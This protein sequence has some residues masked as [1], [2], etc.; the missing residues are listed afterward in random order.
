MI[1]SIKGKPNNNKTGRTAGLS[2]LELKNP[3]KKDLANTNKSD[4]LWKKQP[5]FA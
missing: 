1:L 4:L 5:L 2:H 3:L